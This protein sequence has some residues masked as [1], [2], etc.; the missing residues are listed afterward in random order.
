M[1]VFGLFFGCTKEVLI[2]NPNY[3]I[4]IVTG[5]V[6]GY[7]GD[8]S[9]IYFEFSVNNNSYY[10]SYGDGVNG[11]NVPKGENYKKGDQF[12]VQYDLA[13]LGKSTSSRMLFNYPVKDSSDYRRYIQEF[14]TNPPK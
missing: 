7:T 3:A 5:Y 13:N 14:K 12:M 6:Q 1:M 8:N 2:N 4:G 11:W 10:N 9:H